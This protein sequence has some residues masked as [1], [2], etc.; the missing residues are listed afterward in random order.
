[1]EKTNKNLSPTL[2]TAEDPRQFL[3]RKYIIIIRFIF[4]FLSVINL[5]IF[6]PKALSSFVYLGGVLFYIPLIF[7]SVYLARY[8]MNW[9]YYENYVF[10]TMI[11][12]T[13]FLQMVTFISGRFLATYFFMTIPVVILMCDARF[14]T[15][16][17]FNT[18]GAVCG[19]SFLLLSY[20][21]EP[22]TFFTKE[23]IF[24][25]AMLWF[26]ALASSI[27]MSFVERSRKIIIEASEA[28]KETNVTLEVK[29]N[30]RTKELQE[31]AASLD[32]QVKNKTKDL[33]AKI[34]ELEVFHKLAVG[35]ELKMIELKKEIDAL[36]K[37]LKDSQKSTNGS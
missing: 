33:Q 5:L 19:S 18:F 27:F 7:I 3:D 16:R 12:D 15:K 24:L 30:A 26:I 14:P 13:L 31:L 34:D 2:I 32:E 1:M 20:I 37:P 4:L 10:I 9:K 22:Q 25:Y 35:R 28:L 36:K 17:G 8:K 6:A 23:R 21:A 11:L 29:V